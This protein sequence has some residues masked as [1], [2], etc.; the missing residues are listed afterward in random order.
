MFVDQQ[1]V[2]TLINFGVTIG[3]AAYLYYWYGKPMLQDMMAAREREQT[4]LMHEKQSLRD[5]QERLAR[6]MEQEQ[7]LATSLLEKATQWKQRY[8]QKRAQALEEQQLIDAKV[9]EK[10]HQQAQLYAQ[11]RLYKTI[12]PQVMHQAREQLTSQ[13]KKGKEADAYLK[14]IITFMKKSTR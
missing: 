5:E 11:Q 8:Q 1:L 10:R 12:L 3:L 13:F 9:N 6:V 14:D 2:F 4:L 7:R